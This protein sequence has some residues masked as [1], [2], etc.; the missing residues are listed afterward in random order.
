MKTLHEEPVE[1]NPAI[2]LN[3]S[4]RRLLLGAGLRLFLGRL[5]RGLPILR[6]DMLRLSALA[7]DAGRNS[8][9][10]ARP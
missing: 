6:N 1:F 10:K 5:R 9:E 2:P 4:D 8:R 7:D 3:H